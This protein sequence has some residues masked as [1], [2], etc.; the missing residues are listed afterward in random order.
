MVKKYRVKLGDRVVGPVDIDLIKKIHKNGHI[1]GNEQT[2]EF[3][4][5]EWKPF[6]T[7]KEIQIALISETSSGEGTLLR[8]NPLQETKREKDIKEEVEKTSDQF[9]EFVFEKKESEEVVKYEELQENYDRKKENELGPEET[10]KTLDKTVIIKKEELE[11]FEETKIL[12]KLESEGLSIE[13][14]TQI[15]ESLLEEL[16]EDEAPSFGS[17]DA[18]QVVDLKEIEKL[19]AEK[20]ESEYAL[21]KAR[22]LE[23]LEAENTETF[24]Q[25]ETKT[26]IVT[27]KKKMK[28]IVLFSFIVILG[29]LF[30][31]EEEKKNFEPQLIKITAPIT[32][33][34]ENPSKAKSLLNDG[35]KEYR[36]GSY[37]N[38]VKASHLFKQSVEYQIKDNPALGYLVRCYGEL[39]PNAF[40]R[41][42]ASRTLFNLI[43]IGRKGVYKDVNMAIGTA[44]F[45]KYNNKLQTALD[46]VESYLRISKPTLEILALY[47]NLSIDLGDLVKAEKIQKKLIDFQEKPLEVIL[48]LSKYSNLDENYA[49]GK[50]LIISG[51]KKY[52]G[53]VALLLSLADYLLRDDLRKEYIKTLKSV[54]E[55]NFES[56]PQYFAKYLENMGLLSA[57]NG[58]PKQ[59]ALF[60]KQALK[61]SNSSSLRGKLATLDLGGGKISE[62]LI[63]ESKA[64]D[65]IRKSKKLVRQKKWDDAFRAALAATNL[66]ISYL[67]AEI[68]LVKL[69]IERGF[70]EFSIQKLEKLK[71]VYPRVV[72][73]KF[74]LIEVLTKANKL[75]EA[76]K[77]VSYVTNMNKTHP[78]Y[79]S[80][81]ARYYEKSKKY[82]LAA[83]FLNDGVKKFPLKDED[84]YLMADIFMRNRQYKSAKNKINEAIDLDPLNTDYI[85]LYARI[86]FE[87]DGV[88]TAV[89]YLREKLKTHVD[90][91]KL[92]GEIAIYY[93]ESGQLDLFE[94]TKKE[95]LKLNNKDE[96]FFR[97]LVKAG[98]LEDD[99][100]LIIDS[101]EKLLFIN[102][103][104]LKIRIQLSNEYSVKGKY[105]EALEQL[106][107]IE[108]RLSS[109][110]RVNYYKA[111]V[112][113]KM[114]NYKEALRFAE[115][116]TKNNPYIYNGWYI[117]GETYRLVGEYKKAIKNLEKAI[118]IKPKSVEALKSLG[119]IKLSETQYDVARELYLRAKKNA[120]NDPG[121]RKQ[122]ALVY[123]GIGQSGLAVEE[124][125]VYLKLYP[126]APDRN[127]I[128]QQIRMLSQ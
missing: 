53:S 73:I 13:V 82:I 17:N 58:N 39:I 20:K 6:S 14:D 26:E 127:V 30:F 42:R 2:Q 66:G 93:Y 121:I 111:K 115:K 113:N 61:I 10:Q 18:T 80:V 84:Y 119:W 27:E 55:L 22:E 8:S 70:F 83:K 63:Q 52:G 128:K 126:N 23:N 25:E 94:E 5:G 102:P 12:P 59:A 78:R 56:N 38:K 46:V 37:L 19:R 75:A 32:F 104:D 88:D 48:A 31:D 103:G 40:N 51:L 36:K 4:D 90:N 101:A 110:P 43:K 9:K 64:I 44:N 71:E 116:E 69:Q 114:K 112:Y 15:D 28:P 89:G 7:F 96:D 49:Q 60:F 65:L 21:E 125:E 100:N 33:E 68:N 86:I 67:P 81:V 124:Y 76:Q 99:S 24:I 35:I 95:I 123:R 11:T 122:L 91:P 45:Y 87:L 98:V 3:P 57:L 85:S 16:D 54:Q 97:F 118:S 47:L 106:N 62:K 117:L 108:S 41:E 74:Y 34:V 120:P 50:K 77:L 72:A 1:K 79:Y 92:L 105:K 29:F 107:E 109:Y